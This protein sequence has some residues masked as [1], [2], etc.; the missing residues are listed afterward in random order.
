MTEEILLKAINTYGKVTQC[1]VAMEELSELQKEISKALRGKSNSDNLA[2]EI[3]DVTIMI[4][5]L[6]LIFG[7]KDE[8]VCEQISYKVKRL[9]G[10]LED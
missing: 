2:E 8:E 10:R 6:Q 7:I 9:E 4:M 5:Q 3:A 1:I